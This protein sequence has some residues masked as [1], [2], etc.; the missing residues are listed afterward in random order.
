[1][2]SAIAP[3][4]A[5]TPL[6]GEI[7]V[8]VVEDSIDHQLLMRRSLERDGLDVRVASD[9]D[10][11]LAAVDDV[12]LVLLDYRLPGDT[13]LELLDRI[14]DR[15]RP[16]SVVMVTGAGSTDVAVEAMRAGAID[17]VAKDR[18]YIDRL[19]EV[20]RRAWRHHDLTQRASELQRLAL[21]V[22]SAQGRDELFQEIVAGAQRLLRA[23]A[24]ALLLERHGELHPATVLGEV[25]DDLASLRTL[26]PTLLEPGSGP[27]VESGRMLVA[28]PR[29]GG[30]PLGVLAVWAGD[31]QHGGEELQ[32][33][34]A[35]ASF[36]GIALRN[37]HQRE[38]EHELV[39]ELRQTVDA[40]RDFIASVSHELRTP[41]TC[42]LG[43]V[44]T[45]DQ[46]WERMAA[47]SRL[48]MLQRI[49]RNA[50]DLK[51]LVD[52]LIDLAALDRGRSFH[53]EL[54]ALQL[55]DAVRRSVGDA[56][57]ILADREVDVDA[58]SV[59][60]LADSSLVRRTLTN[61]LTN[62]V[63]FSEPGSPLWLRVIAEEGAARVEVE[64][65]G[66]GMEPREAARVFDPFFRANPSV[67][68]AVRGS[69]IGLALVKEYV[70]TM[71]GGVGVRSEPGEGST[72][73][74]TLPLAD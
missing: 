63:K 32:L 51:V 10:E 48:D 30:V 26:D 3:G 33:V 74:F 28:L 13:G 1:M 58:A 4:H 2:L 35:F 8:L 70:R 19:P 68:N 16:P 72:F 29:E 46:G 49:G 15:E 7:R 17:Y 22:S 62:A 38:L 44:D 11:A 18:G 55:D 14:R 23:R 66:I 41:L 61:L 64:D 34:R 5:N 57:E 25:P 31:R 47:E 12:D 37:L 39:S 73:W 9:A 6:R 43:F 54:E 20:V 69:G 42:I 53:V 65:R 60:A 67:A 21:L 59:V 36:V 45:L 71:G 27:M 40:R 52:E 24:C 56:S 50:G